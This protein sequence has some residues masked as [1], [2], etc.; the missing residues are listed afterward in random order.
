MQVLVDMVTVVVAELVHQRVHHGIILFITFDK[1][2]VDVV[3]YRLTCQQLR[4][5]VI[6]ALLRHFQE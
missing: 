5:E 1:E 4:H 6:V 3:V 2:L